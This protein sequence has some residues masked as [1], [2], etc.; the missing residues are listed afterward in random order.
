[1]IV[2]GVGMDVFGIALR[3]LIS[4]SPTFK[5]DTYLIIRIKDTIFLKRTWRVFTSGRPS[6]KHLAQNRNL[7]THRDFR[8]VWARFFC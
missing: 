4:M 7:E 5:P 3:M 6:R 1:M 8:S 2:D